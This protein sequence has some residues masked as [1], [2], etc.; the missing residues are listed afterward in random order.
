MT[1]TYKGYFDAMP[2]YLSVQDRDL[3]IVEGL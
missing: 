3:R 2:C 1:A